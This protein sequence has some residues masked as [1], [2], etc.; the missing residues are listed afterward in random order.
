ML[1]FTFENSNTCLNSV[2][3]IHYFP[4]QKIKRTNACFKAFCHV[5]M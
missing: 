1:S 5:G 2:E 4:Q 3:H